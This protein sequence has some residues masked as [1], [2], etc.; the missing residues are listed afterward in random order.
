MVFFSLILALLSGGLTLDPNGSVAVFSGTLQ[1]KGIV[2]QGT[3]PV[4]QGAPV[5]LQG[6]S[7]RLQ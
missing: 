5:Y 4:L 3:S 2:L 7:T 6:S 1:P